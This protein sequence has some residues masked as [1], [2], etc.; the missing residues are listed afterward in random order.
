MN[1][2]LKLSFELDE[3][4]RLQAIPEEEIRGYAFEKEEYNPIETFGFS[5]RDE[6]NDIKGRC[7]GILY[8]GCLYI[9]QL[10]ID[11]DYRSKGFGR[12]LIKAAE[13]FGKEKGCLFSTVNTMNSEAMGF[14]KKLGYFIEF[15]RKGYQ[16]NS[17][18]YFL[19]KDFTKG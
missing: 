6:G 11:K 17:I 15:Q 14:Y 3:L 2:E 1:Q 4:K 8:Y 5:L 16:K 7:N 10:W 13:N 12:Q 18:F 19:R 9:N